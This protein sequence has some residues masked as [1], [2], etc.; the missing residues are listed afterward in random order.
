M[1]QLFLVPIELAILLQWL[2][3]GDELPVSPTGHYVVHHAGAIFDVLL[4][5]LCNSN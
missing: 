4:S 1:A 3:R 2:A 5:R